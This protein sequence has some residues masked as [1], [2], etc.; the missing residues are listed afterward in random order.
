MR[1]LYDNTLLDYFILI[2]HFVAP[3]N[4]KSR[5]MGV[6]RSSI[7]G[8]FATGFTRGI[9]LMEKLSSQ[10]AMC[11]IVS[12]LFLCPDEQGSE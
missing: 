1:I 6:M 11:I 2:I 3:L 9:S 5:T 12:K 7:M 8:I 10:L 4:E